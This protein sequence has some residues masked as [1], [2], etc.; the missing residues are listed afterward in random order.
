MA[1]K[2]SESEDRIAEFWESVAVHVEADHGLF[3][4]D[5]DLTPA[6]IRVIVEWAQ[7]TAYGLR[8]RASRN[9]SIGS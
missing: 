5:T 7:G 9:R 4:E 3:N 2:Q 1:R 8:Q 6:E